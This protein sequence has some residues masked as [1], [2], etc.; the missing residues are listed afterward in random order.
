MGHP[1]QGRGSPFPSSEVS[2]KQVSEHRPV[3]SPLFAISTES[4]F[5]SPQSSSSIIVLIRNII[6]KEGKQFTPTI[7]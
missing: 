7:V 6:H 3:Q 5:N 1:E 4:Q 2:K